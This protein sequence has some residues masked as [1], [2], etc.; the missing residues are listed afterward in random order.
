[1]ASGKVRSGIRFGSYSK[2]RRGEGDTYRMAFVVATPF[3]HTHH[4]ASY[5]TRARLVHSRITGDSP[6]SDERRD[7]DGLRWR[8]RLT[9]LVLPF[10]TR[11]EAT[12][13]EVNCHGL[14]VRRCGQPP[15]ERPLCPTSL[16]DM[17]D[18]YGDPYNWTDCV[19]GMSG[20]IPVLATGT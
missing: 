4:R 3:S 15:R 20:E 11:Q 10:A 9:R 18:S 14:A 5:R 1:M 19:C 13:G 2:E 16:Q 6:R 17:S 12:P 8:G 7:N